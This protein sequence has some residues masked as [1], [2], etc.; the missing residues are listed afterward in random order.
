MAAILANA[1]FRKAQDEKDAEATRIEKLRDACSAKGW[2]WDAEKLNCKRPPEADESKLGQDI[3]GLTGN[4]PDLDE[5][6]LGQDITGTSGIVPLPLE[7][8][9][10]LP[11][12][13]VVN[14]ADTGR[15]AG[16]I[17]SVGEFV[18]GSRQDI[19]AVVS[20]ENKQ[21]A[22]IEGGVTTQQIQQQKEIAQ[23]ASK[24]GLTDDEISSLQSGI[25]GD[26][27]INWSQAITAGTAGNLGKIATYGVGALVVSGGNP[28][29]AALGVASAIWSGVQGNIKTQQSGEIGASKDVLTNAKTNMMKLSRL[30][31]TDPS[32]ADDYIQAYNFWLGEVYKARR[33]IKLETQG[34]LNAFMEDGRDILSDYDLFLMEDVGTAA[35]YKQRILAELQ[36]ETSTEMKIA[37]MLE[38]EEI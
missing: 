15:P 16:F 33:Q 29:V 14:D 32:H 7:E 20:G 18:R 10:S 35:I 31:S 6:K 1:S 25:T 27:P 22:P 8:K 34:D 28:I 37:Q 13:T 36:G 11:R 24:F 9:E 4:R 19:Q 30:A 12:G 38:E 23:L 21:N 3:T 2:V 5:S 17:N 26:A